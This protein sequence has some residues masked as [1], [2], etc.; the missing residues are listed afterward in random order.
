MILALLLLAFADTLTTPKE[1]PKDRQEE[2]SRAMLALQGAQIATK[3]A[4]L[5]AVQ[6]KEREQQATQ[7]YLTLIEKLRKEYGVPA[8]CQITMDKTW[9]CPPAPAKDK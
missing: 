6:A 2:V 9:A 3:D 8:D 1:L 7:A 5:A 4:Q